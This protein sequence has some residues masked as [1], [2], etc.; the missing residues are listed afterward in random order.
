MAQHTHNTTRLVNHDEIT[1]S[2]LEEY[3][4][5][6]RR[7]RRLVT[8]NDILDAI[9]VPHDRVG[10]GNPAIDGRNA[11]LERISLQRENKNNTS[12]PHGPTTKKKHK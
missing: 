12:A 2:V 1:F 7:D 9:A 5:G 4:D 10:L 11:R 3:L 6:F 8:M